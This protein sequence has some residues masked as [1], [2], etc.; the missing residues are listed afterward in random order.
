VVKVG[1]A[2]R[3]NDRWTL[4][5]GYNRGDNPITPSDVTFNI[6]APG[7]MKDHYTAGFTWAMGS[8]SEVTGALMFAPRQSVTGASLFNAVMGPGAG[9]TETIR[10]R[11]TS[12]GV[13][14]GR[15]F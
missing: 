9:G 10:M 7:V 8:G 14:W 12:L 5:A 2:W 3:M 13:A 6:L 11:E 15:K 4:R 1:A